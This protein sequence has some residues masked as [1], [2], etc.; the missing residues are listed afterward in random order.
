MNYSMWTSYY[1]ELTPEEMVDEFQSAGWFNL[2]LSTE[3]SAELLKR[4]DPARIGSEFKT[5]AEEH[6]IRFSQGH[7]WLG[8]DV[9]GE[10]SD[11]VVDELKRWLDLYLVLGIKAGVIHSGGSELVKNGTDAAIVLERR[12]AAFRALSAHVRDTDLTI[13]LENTTGDTAYASELLAIIK[14]A[15]DKNLGICLDTGH[16][17]ISKGIQ[18]DFIR[19]AGD[20]LRALHIADNEGEFDQHLMPYGRGTVDWDDVMAG[21]SEIEYSG[22]FN[23]EIPGETRAPLAVKRM[24]L[25]Y[26]KQVAEY[27]LG[28]QE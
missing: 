1:I 7:L 18:S 26:A 25:G 13:C 17:H 6:G 20:H 28:K 8:C 23:M 9:A 10:E 14:A 15:G 22:L 21:L 3:H 4:G 12:A 24:K 5:Y 16:L 11:A 19:T 2:E 27:M